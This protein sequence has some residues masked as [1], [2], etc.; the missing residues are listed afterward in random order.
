LLPVKSAQTAKPK[1]MWSASARRAWR[2]AA[3][4]KAAERAMAREEDAEEKEKGSRNLV[5]TVTAVPPLQPQARVLNVTTVMNMDTLRVNA[6]RRRK[7]SLRGRTKTKVVLSPQS[8]SLTMCRCLNV[9][10]IG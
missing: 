1:A 5:T 10:T 2:R 6:R 8:L 3:A 7:T 4:V 9:C